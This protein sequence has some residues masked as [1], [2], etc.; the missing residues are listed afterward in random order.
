MSHASEHTVDSLFAAIGS[1][2]IDDQYA[3]YNRLQDELHGGHDGEEEEALFSLEWQT[4]IKR[5]IAD[6]D[7]GLG[8][9]TPAEEVIAEARASRKRSETAMEDRKKEGDF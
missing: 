1:L 8:Q 7:S 6:C 5:R 9:F 3:L 2:P 4:E